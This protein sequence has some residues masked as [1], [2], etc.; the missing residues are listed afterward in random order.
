MTVTREVFIASIKGWQNSTEKRLTLS[1]SLV[2]TW[3]AGKQAGNQAGNS[4]AAMLGSVGKRR[5]ADTAERGSGGLHRRDE[6][7]GGAVRSL[8]RRAF[9]VG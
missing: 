1:F 9:V 6:G 5:G 3:R 2:C 7:G 4:R 8:V